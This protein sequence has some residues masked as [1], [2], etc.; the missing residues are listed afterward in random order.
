MR[1]STNETLQAARWGD[2]LAR[3]ILDGEVDVEFVIR[4]LEPYASQSRCDRLR[5]VFSQRIGRVTLVLD[6]LHD[7][8]NGAAMLRTSE[9][10]G[11]AR[12]HVV[13]RG[14]SFL[15]HA[16]VAR[17]THKWVQVLAHETAESCVQT[18]AATGHELIATHPDGELM[19]RDLTGIERVALVL[20]NEHDGIAPAIRAACV[21]TV[22]VPMRGF[23]E[24]L[25]VSVCG[26][27]LLAYATEGRDG[28]LDPAEL[29]R[30]Y[31][32]GL[33]VSVPHAPALLE[34]ADA[35]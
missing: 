13:E 10:L 14:E 8:H 21:R 28:D 34:H 30:L 23:A 33:A 22:R 19:P 7:P 4:V 9:A 24:S 16:G 27:I 3:R 29:R 5:Q 18:L 17:G 12:V 6:A 25:N 32:R 26:G 11:L 31:A 20:G 15:A 35:R 2:R 1:R